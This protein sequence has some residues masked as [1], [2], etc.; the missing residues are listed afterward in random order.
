MTIDGVGPAEVDTVLKIIPNYKSCVGLDSKFEELC[1]D[2]LL[3]FI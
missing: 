1:Q 2:P 3:K